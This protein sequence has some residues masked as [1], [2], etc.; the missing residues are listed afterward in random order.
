MKTHFFFLASLALT[1]ARAWSAV[2]IRLDFLPPRIRAGSL[3]TNLQF[4][5]FIFNGRNN[6]HT[7]AA[8]LNLASMGQVDDELT[9]VQREVFHDDN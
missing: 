9:W 4:G 5:H 3:K 2:R 1:I 7:I 8:A 6:F